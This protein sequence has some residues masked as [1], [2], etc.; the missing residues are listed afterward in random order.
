MIDFFTGSLTLF[1]RIQDMTILLHVSQASCFI[2]SD[3]SLLINP[4][5]NPNF[6]FEASDISMDIFHDL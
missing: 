3:S 5:T 1:A 6:L 4:V 2:L